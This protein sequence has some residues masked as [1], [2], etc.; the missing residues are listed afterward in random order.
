MRATRAAIKRAADWPRYMTAKRMRGKAAAGRVASY[1]EPQTADRVAGFTMP[2]EALG[3]DYAAARDR[4]AML[5]AHLDAWRAGKAEPRSL[6]AGAKAGT[7]DWW[8]EHYYRSEAFTRLAQ[9]T[10]ADYR[11]AL[12]RLADVE[13]KLM[14]CATG[15]AVRFGELPVSSVTPVA[16]DKLHAKL[17]DGGRLSRQANAA[18]DVARRAWKVVAR[19]YPATFLIANPD[20]PSDR[21]A[22]NPWV[23]VLR[24]FGAGTTQPC[25]REEAF[26]L[27]DALIALGHPTLGIVPIVAFELLQRPE[28]IIAGHLT[29][30]QSRPAARPTEIEFFH[31]KTGERIW[32]PL[33]I[34][35]EAPDGAPAVRQLYPEPET[36][37]ATLPKPGVPVVMLTPRRGPKGPDGK[38]QPR[39]YSESH[40]DHLV[41][42]ARATAGLPIHVTFAACRHGGMTLLGDAALTGS[43]IMS[44]SGDVTPAAAR[45]YVKRTEARRLRAAVQRCAFIEQSRP[46]SRNG[47]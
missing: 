30:K 32:H 2:A 5:N 21:I 46:K 13:T 41:Q 18:I 38:R 33:E 16:V 42:K 43:E 11:E 19:A 35:D 15:R 3:T 28:N 22:L 23:G 47:S 10:Q 39:L 24:T 45:I 7:V 31:H 8:H 9:R 29:W 36:R 4:A 26:A 14:D 27:A 1:W 34:A 37:L 6:D 40:A 12:G 44:L 25:T 20:A 17:R